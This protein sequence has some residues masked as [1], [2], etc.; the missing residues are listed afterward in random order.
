MRVSDV[1]RAVGR[2]FESRKAV[3]DALDG[4]PANGG[5]SGGGR[6]GVETRGDFVVVFVNVGDGKGRRY[7]NEFWEEESSG[8]RRHRSEADADGGGAEEENGGDA[9]DVGN[10]EDVVVPSSAGTSSSAAVMMSWF[11]GTRADGAPRSVSEILRASR[12][13][14]AAEA[15]EGE[16]GPRFANANENENKT[17]VL[18]LRVGRGGPY[19]CCGRLVAAGVRAGGEGGAGTRIDFRLA[20][21]D[22]LRASGAFRDAVGRFLRA[23]GG[24][25]VAVGAGR[26]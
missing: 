10:A 16:P 25:G 14:D 2:S 5:G 7:G 9:E 13:A 23:P 21:A 24:E 3:A 4:Y 6:G 8:R 26:G 15:D 11:S 12:E 17:A 22:R 19:V 1:V 20:D 18:F